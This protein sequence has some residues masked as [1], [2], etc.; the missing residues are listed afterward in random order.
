MLYAV[1]D[2]PTGQEEYFMWNSTSNLTIDGSP[3]CGFEPVNVSV[4]AEALGES[5]V[6]F[7]FLF[8]FLD[9]WMSLS[10]HFIAPFI[11]TFH[12]IDLSGEFSFNNVEFTDLSINV[13]ASLED[14]VILSKCKFL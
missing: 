14:V 4:P 9:S 8:D 5:S 6:R 1:V 10:D 12:S 13:E 2:K 7:K 3:T 11:K